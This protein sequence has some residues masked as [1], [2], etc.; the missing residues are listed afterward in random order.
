[1]PTKSPTQSAACPPGCEA[2]T[3]EDQVWKD[4]EVPQQIQCSPPR[5]IIPCPSQQPHRTPCICRNTRSAAGP[6]P[7]RPSWQVCKGSQRSACHCLIN[8]SYLLRCGCLHSG[9]AA[10]AGHCS[11]CKVWALHLR[12][13]CLLRCGCLFSGAAAPAGHCGGCRPWA[14]LF[15]FQEGTHCTRLSFGRPYTER[16]SCSRPCTRQ[17]SCSRLCRKRLSCD[18]SRAERPSCSRP[19]IE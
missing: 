2:D 6:L 7:K 9:A 1:M 5:G 15:A 12:S 10:P 11:G 13:S 8:S 4:T 19:C 17:R 3:G 18:R 16:P 14:P